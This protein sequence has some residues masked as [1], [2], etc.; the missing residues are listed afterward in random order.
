MD[1]GLSFGLFYCVVCP[2]SIY[3]FWFI[4]WHLQTFLKTYTE[5]WG[6]N[7]IDRQTVTFNNPLLT[8]KLFYTSRRSHY[9]SKNQLMTWMSKRML[10]I[11]FISHNYFS[12]YFQMFLNIVIIAKVTFQNL[13][14]KCRLGLYYLT[15]LSTIFQLYRADQFYWWRKL[16]YPE[17]TTDLPQVTGNFQ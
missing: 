11:W 7:G 5:K 9:L 4:P 10:C 8:N 2:S 17:N 16:E 13:N 1:H 14:S 12:I 3:G 15:P 6:H